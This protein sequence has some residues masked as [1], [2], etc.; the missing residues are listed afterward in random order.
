[1]FGTIAGLSGLFLWFLLPTWVYTDAMQRDARSP[2]LWALLSTI[3]LFFGLTIYLMTRPSTYR[4]FHCPQCEK[5]LNG[6]K[7]FC[8]HCGFDLAGTFCSQCQYPIKQSWQF[9]PNCRAE[10]G[11]RKV[12]NDAEINESAKEE[13]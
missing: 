10:L 12:K 11:E 2:G 5:E 4:S 3:S 6:T 1:V 7:A 13:G 9:C 8:P